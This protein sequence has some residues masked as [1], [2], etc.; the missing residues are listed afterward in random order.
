MTN[1]EKAKKIYS[2]ILAEVYGWSGGEFD[3]NHGLYDMILEIIE[4]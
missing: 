2:A 3:E 4:G 1:E